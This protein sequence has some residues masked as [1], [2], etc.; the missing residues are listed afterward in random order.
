MNYIIYVLIPK[1]WHR[2]SGAH[3]CKFIELPHGILEA[4]SQWER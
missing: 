1:E 3:V 4:G 2:K